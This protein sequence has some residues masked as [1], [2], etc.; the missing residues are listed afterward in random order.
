[1]DQREDLGPSPG[2]IIY[3]T[4]HKT[5]IQTVAILNFLCIKTE[6]P[7]RT[8]ATSQGGCDN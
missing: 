3:S 2:S 6:F 7:Q 5:F 8:T 1:M 4:E